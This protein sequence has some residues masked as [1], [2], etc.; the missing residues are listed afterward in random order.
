MILQSQSTSRKQLFTVMFTLDTEA[1]RFLQQQPESGFQKPV[2]VL[3]LEL[4]WSSLVTR[5]SPPSLLT[6]PRIL[7]IP[8][9]KVPPITLVYTQAN[10]HIHKE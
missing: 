4:K 8:L 9:A 2:Q 5:A 10:T 3:G 7:N 6:G 1:A